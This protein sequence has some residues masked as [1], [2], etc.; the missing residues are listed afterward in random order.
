MGEKEVSDIKIEAIV[1]GYTTIEKLLDSTAYLAGNNL[2]L[3]DLCLWPNIESI[4][5]IIPMEEANYPKIYKWM[6]R[7]R[8]LPYSDELN[9]K[10][11]DQHVK[12]FQD[13]LIKNNAK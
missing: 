6:E 11:A 7:L 4:M 5:Q 1:K 9:K 10:G 3:A 13:S 2:T 8:E 12:G